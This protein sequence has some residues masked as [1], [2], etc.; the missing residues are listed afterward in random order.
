MA[1]SPA[2]GA[3]NAWEP[4]VPPVKLLA[5]AGAAFCLTAAAAYAEE[6]DGLQLPPG[7]H[8]TVVADGLK[9]MRHLAVRDN[10]DVYVSTRAG[11]GETSQG[12]IALHIGPDGKADRIEHF[13]SVEGGTGIRFYRGAL[14]ASSVTGVYRFDF[15]GD[16][17]APSAP[18]KV[19][20]DGMPTGGQVNR[21]FSFDDKGGLYVSVAGTGNICTEAATPKVGLKPCP[22]LQGRGGVWRFDARKLGQSFPAGGEQV[23]TGVRD[24][25][26]MDWR[27][28]DGLYA[29]VQGRNG[30]AAVW[31]EL[32]SASDEANIADEML[33]I[34]KGANLGWPYTYYDAVRKVR[35]NAPEYGGDNKT[36]PAPGTYAD[37]VVAFAGHSSPLD[38]VFYEARQFP[39]AYRGGAFVAMHGGGGAPTPTGHNGYDVLFVPFD[40]AGH[41]GAPQRFAEGFA[42]PTDAA[43]NAATAVYRPVGLAVAKDGSLY[44]ADSQKGRLWRISYRP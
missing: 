19:V 39:A 24:M 38:L 32:V 44:V 43:K 25:V 28:G 10:G 36:G 5:A 33:R 6:P 2:T 11:R 18:A 34:R 8:A 27:P 17:L 37:P 20:L 14:Y 35:L 16:E 22:G 42:G 15:A 13:G 12:V 29:A 9:G 41:A 31:P 30:V 4:A 40:R 7:F 1:L 21:V 3:L 26:G 23:A